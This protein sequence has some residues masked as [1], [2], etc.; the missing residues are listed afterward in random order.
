[1]AARTHRVAVYTRRDAAERDHNL[2]G[3]KTAPHEFEG[4]K[5]RETLGGWFSFDMAVAPDVPNTLYCT[6][7]G[8]RFYNHS[9]DIEIDGRKV[10]FENIH[11]WGRSTSSAAT[12]FRRS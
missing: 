8:N 4:R 5:Y 7:W 10:G 6:Y 9:F 2:R 11:N 12:G 3:E 1:M